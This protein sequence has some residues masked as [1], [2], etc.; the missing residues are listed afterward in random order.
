MEFNKQELLIILL[1]LTNNEESLREEKG[2]KLVRCHDTEA[3]KGIKLFYDK[4]IYEFIKLR[5]RI[6]KET[7]KNHWKIIFKNLLTKA[8]FH[9]ILYS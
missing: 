4:K 1:S 8:T 5:Q 7:D 3:Y 9:D 2:L 6:L